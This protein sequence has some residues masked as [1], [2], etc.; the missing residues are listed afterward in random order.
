MKRITILKRKVLKKTG[1]PIERPKIRG[2]FV[3]LV[4]AVFRS[5]VKPFVI[6]LDDVTEKPPRFVPLVIALARAM[7]AEAAAVL[8][9]LPPAVGSIVPT[10]ATDFF[11]IE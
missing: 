6:T 10:N 4:V 1:I 8:E 3:L 7:D 5:I 2:K 9:V 11:F